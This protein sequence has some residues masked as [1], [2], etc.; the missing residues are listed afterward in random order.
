MN[1]RPP[2]GNS[3]WPPLPPGNKAFLERWAKLP[4]DALAKAIAENEAEDKA[5]LESVKGEHARSLLPKK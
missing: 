5:F 1:K 4:P 3:A 2:S